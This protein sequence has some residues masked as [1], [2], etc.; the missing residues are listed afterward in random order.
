MPGQERRNSRFDDI[1]ILLYDMWPTHF[2][3]QRSRKQSTAAARRT[4]NFQTHCVPFHS[5]PEPLGPILSIFLCPHMP[6]STV[7]GRQLGGMPPSLSPF[8]PS[9]LS[10]SCRDGSTRPLVSSTQR[11]R[12]LISLLVFQT[13]LCCTPNHGLK[14][15]FPYPSQNGA[16]LFS[17]PTA[18]C[19][20][21]PTTPQPRSFSASPTSPAKLLSA[22]RLLWEPTQCSVSPV[23]HLHPQNH[24]SICIGCTL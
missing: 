21:N 24:P 14:L 9:P 22:A 5:E 12:P 8:F 19:H 23:L 13:S 15:N 20:H 17:L 16:L 6:W 1:L 10:K 2:H 4:V 18:F 11:L 3:L 7:S